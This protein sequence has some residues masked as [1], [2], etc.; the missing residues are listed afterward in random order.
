[1]QEVEAICDRIIIINKGRIV[2]NDTAD[3]IQTRVEDK[4]LKFLIEF[5][6]DV[7]REDLEKIPGVE[8]VH[9]LKH[10]R[11]IIVSLDDVRKNIFEFAVKR[12]ITVLTMEQKRKSLEEIFQELTK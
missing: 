2:A 9:Y 1:M 11:W 7:L 8:E 10:N 3:A 5:D 4:L 12:Q 6:K